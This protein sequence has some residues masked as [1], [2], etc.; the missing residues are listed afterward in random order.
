MKS[1]TLHASMIGHPNNGLSILGEWA[2]QQELRVQDVCQ[3]KPV[4]MD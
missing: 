2:G 4:S 3:Q 1:M